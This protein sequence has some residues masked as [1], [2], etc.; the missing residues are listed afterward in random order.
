MPPLMEEAM[1]GSLSP[2]G[3]LSKAE[4][5]STAAFPTPETKNA[6]WPPGPSWVESW[7]QGARVDLLSPRCLLLEQKVS[8]PG[9]ALSTTL[10]GAAPC[11]RANQQSLLLLRL[12]EMSP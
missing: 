5:L 9:L 3:F 11:P 4:T 1:P 10:G 8:F 6:L 2:K 12:L 7:G